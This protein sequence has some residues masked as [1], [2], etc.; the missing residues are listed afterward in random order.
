MYITFVDFID[1]SYFFI[2]YN[3]SPFGRCHHRLN[4]KTRYVSAQVPDNIPT[5]VQPQKLLIESNNISCHLVQYGLHPGTLWESGLYLVIE[6]G[7][8]SLL[9]HGRV[10]R[11]VEGQVRMARKRGRL[12]LSEKSEG[13]AITSSVIN[14]SRVLGA[15]R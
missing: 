9:D 12:G 14:S 15:Q 4:G 2:S 1:Y 13:K 8:M 6:L 5:A 11:A 10:V 7:T 3:I